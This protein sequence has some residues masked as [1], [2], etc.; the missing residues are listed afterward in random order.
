MKNKHGG[1]L[2]LLKFQTS[3]CNCTKSNPSPWVLFMFMKLYKWYHIMQ[4]I[5]FKEIYSAYL[6]WKILFKCSFPLKCTSR[7]SGMFFTIRFHLY[8]WEIPSIWDIFFPCNCSIL[9]KQAKKNVDTCLKIVHKFIQI[10]SW[11]KYFAW[12]NSK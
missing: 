3:V 11:N 4:S 6:E 5:S 1:L 2:F 12:R 7:L 8:K 9:A 10:Q